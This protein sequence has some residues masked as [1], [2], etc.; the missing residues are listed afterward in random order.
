MTQDK[1]NNIDLT[2]DKII[3]ALDLT[4]LTQPHDFSEIKV[5]GGYTSD[6]LSCVM[7]SAMHQG[8]WVTLQ[9][10]NNVV[11]VAALLDLAAIIITEGAMPDLA[12][13]AKANE[14]N[15]VLLLTQKPSFHVVGKL[16]EMGVRSE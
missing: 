14:E 16:W 13:I 10:H 5:A 11:A 9:A 15:V 8:L 3:K 1:P 7:A 2:L 4:L 6:L 12:T